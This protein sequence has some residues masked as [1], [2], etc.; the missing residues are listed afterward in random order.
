MAPF[1]SS[2]LTRIDDAI[3]SGA[4]MVRYGDGRTVTY[5]SVDELL[6]AREV[7]LRN[8]DDA[9]Q[10]PQRKVAAFS[11][12]IEGEGLGSRRRGGGTCYP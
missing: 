9:P 11:T 3:A 6:R 2:D 8:L 5:R 4:L 12:G 1:S 7:V 10:A